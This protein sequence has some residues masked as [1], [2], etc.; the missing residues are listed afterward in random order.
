MTSRI[1]KPGRTTAPG[2]RTIA[3]L[4]SP[5]ALLAAALAGSLRAG[6][7]DLGTL[8]PKP[9]PA[10]AKPNDPK[11]PAKELFGRK[12]TAAAMKA[13]TIGF[14]SKGCLAGAGRCRSTARPGR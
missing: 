2:R 11:T 14:Y 3:P 5:A 4:L 7:Q 8:D 1:R 12:T 9:L 6:A 10:L 13:Q